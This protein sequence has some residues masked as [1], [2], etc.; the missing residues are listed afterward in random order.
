MVQSATYIAAF[1][2]AAVV[3][4]CVHMQAADIMADM[5]GDCVLYLLHTMSCLTLQPPPNMPPR[6]SH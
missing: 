2:K 4:T 1:G 3:G 6:A 5:R